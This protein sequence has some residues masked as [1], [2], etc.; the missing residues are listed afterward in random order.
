MEFSIHYLLKS[1]F[2]AFLAFS[3]HNSLY[4]AA[5]QFFLEIAIF[6]I[7]LYIPYTCLYVYNKFMLCLMYD[8]FLL[9]QDKLYLVTLRKIWTA[10][11]GFYINF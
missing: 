6:V 3:A 4:T 11:A 9:L 2:H 1:C 10:L 7:I 8:L 5:F